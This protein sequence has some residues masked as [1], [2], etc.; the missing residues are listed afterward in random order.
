MRES[1]RGLDAWPVVYLN[2]DQIH[3]LLM[4]HLQKNAGESMDTAG[5]ILAEMDADEIR[6]AFA[7]TWGSKTHKE[8]LSG[9]AAMTE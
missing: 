8:I 6:Q 9:I 1:C 3:G 5:E 2:A 4:A 7:S